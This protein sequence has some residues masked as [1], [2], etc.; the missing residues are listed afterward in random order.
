MFGFMNQGGK[1]DGAGRRPRRHADGSRAESTHAKRPQF[2]K[3]RPL[4]ITLEVTKDTPS[5]A[6]RASL[7]SRQRDSVRPSHQRERLTE[8]DEPRVMHDESRST[9]G[10]NGERPDAPSVVRHQ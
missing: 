5:S 7:T 2:T 4:H 6:Q 1:R 10:S 3:S 8:L 9:T